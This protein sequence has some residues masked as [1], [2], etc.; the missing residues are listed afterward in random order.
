MG[1]SIRDLEW[2]AGFLEGEGT[3]N[4]SIDNRG[5]SAI[6]GKHYINYKVVVTQVNDEPI[7]RLRNLFGGTVSLR[8]RYD[9]QDQFLW[10]TSGA[11]ARGIMMTLFP[12]M[13]RVKQ[14]QIIRSLTKGHATDGTQVH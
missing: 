12:L 7:Y 3:F 8:E 4:A 5:K 14:E 1:V 13:S 6:T 9:G 10:T 11:R 2:A